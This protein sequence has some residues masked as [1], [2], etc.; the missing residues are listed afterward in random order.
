MTISP[1]AAPFS[2]PPSSGGP[3][4][5]SANTDFVE[6]VEEQ[7][8]QR[9]GHDAVAVLEA[10]S[11]PSAVP[12][13]GL[14]SLVAGLLG[15][16]AAS[17]ERPCAAEEGDGDGTTEPVTDQTEDAE[18]LGVP[19]VA[20][21]TIPTALVAPGHMS[22]DQALQSEGPLDVGDG[23]LRASP[24]GGSQA[25]TGPGSTAGGLEA[26]TGGATRTAREGRTPAGSADQPTVTGQPA[27]GPGAATLAGLPGAT[28]LSGPGASAATAAPQGVHGSAVTEQVFGHVTRLVS[29]GDGTHR[30]MLRLHPADLGEVRVVLTVRDGT[31]DVALSAGPA[32]REALQQGSPHLRAL[33]ELAGATAGDVVVRD[34]VTAGSVAPSTGSGS[35]ASSGH[36]QSTGGATDQ[37]TQ[38]RPGGGDA[39]AAGGGGTGGQAGPGHGDPGSGSTGVHSARASAAAVRPAAS[40]HDA[41]PH[42]SRLDLNL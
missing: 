8:A 34:L 18:V 1:V 24:V 30:L 25:S 2:A 12:S 21:S 17:G 27:G 28:A 26:S 29:R 7:L 40:P 38:G 41:G 6:L 37:A 10:A 33:L 39:F 15:V 4:G 13:E 35:P 14:A 16:P 5:G 11:A 32:A 42:Q 31:V 23:G 3:S 19:T 36:Q 22:A 20:V 9:S